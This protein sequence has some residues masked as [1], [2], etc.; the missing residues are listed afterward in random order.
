MAERHEPEQ[1]E[2]EE[3]QQA[4]A[5]EA[6]ATETAETTAEQP[7]SAELAAEV[8]KLRDA[9]LRTRADMDN[10]QKRAE[11]DMDRAR[12]YQ[13][14]ALMRDLLPV[15]D[16]LEQGLE[17][18]SE[19][20]AASEGLQLTHKLLLKALSDHGL[21]VLDP[22]GERFDPQWHEAMSMQPS[23]DAEPDT[24]LMVLQKGYRLDDRLLRAARVI[25][26]AAPESGKDD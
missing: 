6:E 2:A 25:V 26:T 23:E 4:R 15:I 14:E 10:M 13:H 9:L 1:T 7:E 17:N 8:N 21:E 20:D 11:R 19:E 3:Q 24:V 5:E 16:G 18:A 22:V 12:R